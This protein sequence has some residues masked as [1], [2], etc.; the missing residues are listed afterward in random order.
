MN[1]D[2]I[3]PVF[4]GWY[5]CGTP[6]GQQ[7]ASSQPSLVLVRNQPDSQLGRPKW[8][9][10]HWDLPGALSGFSIIK[11]CIARTLNFFQLKPLR[12]FVH[13]NYNRLIELKV[14]HI[15]QSILTSSHYHPA[16]PKCNQ[17]VSFDSKD[18][19]PI[20]CGQC[21]QK[22]TIKFI[23]ERLTCHLN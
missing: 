21:K 18:E 15:H 10:P 22:A 13:L 9:S 2:F 7:V 8:A 3:S 16:K 19:Q 23:S 17:S 12:C 4:G 20:R 14:F 5:G 11:C 1:F 6:A